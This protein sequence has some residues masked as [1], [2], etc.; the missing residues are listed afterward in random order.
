E[1][2]RAPL[3]L[4][5]AVARLTGSDLDRLVDETMGWIEGGS[6]A[7]SHVDD[8][9]PSQVA[10]GF[11]GRGGK[12]RTVERNGSGGDPAA[13]AGIS[14]GGEADRRF[15]GARLSDEADNL[16]AHDIEG[17]VVDDWY[18]AILLASLD[19]QAPYRQQLAA[20]GGFT[21]GH[22]GLRQI[23]KCT[24]RRRN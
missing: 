20:G 22:C 21:R 16:A 11:A 19:F 24:S 2:A 5:T 4:L 7:L 13:G 23:R 14:Q 18:P 9:L 17:N 8:P 1:F 12:F 6:C 10:Q 15:A 3:Q